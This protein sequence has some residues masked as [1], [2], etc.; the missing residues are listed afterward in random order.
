MMTSS[1]VETSV[2]AGLFGCVH[3]TIS[4]PT[5]MSARI[6]APHFPYRSVFIVHPFLM[7]LLMLLRENPAK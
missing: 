5:R 3:P 1:F 6:I 7:V 4:V 2:F